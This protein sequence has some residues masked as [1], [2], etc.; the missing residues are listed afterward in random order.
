MF[1]NQINNDTAAAAHP[2]TALIARPS[3][4]PAVPKGSR[5]SSRHR[6]EPLRSSSAAAYAK[7]VRLFEAAG[8]IVP[9]D[10]AAI[11]DF[12][13]E[14]RD[15]I[16]PQTIYR[17]L[18]AVRNEHIRLGYA[19]PTDTPA[20]RP[21]LRQMQLGVAPSKPGTAPAPDTKRN[22]PRQARP[23]TRQLLAQVL[24]AMGTNA[25][26]RRDRCLLL[27]GFAAA[28]SRSALISLDAPDVRF[29]NDAMVVTIRTAATGDSERA[30]VVRI[31]FTGDELCAA[32]AT[33]AL[34]EHAQLD[35]EGG[36]L[37]RRHDRAGDPTQHRL[38]SAWVSVVVKN[39]L[40]DVGIDSGSYSAMS[41]R[42]GRLAEGGKGAV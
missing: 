23:I 4:S 26:D 7:D 25:L 10:A 31:P 5:R 20:L 33:R 8:G 32:T 1:S 27:L 36:P 12:I 37:F 24:A 16:A 9:C 30:R 15:K 2:H 13:G 18:M 17:R 34:I 28:L 35:V 22:E 41:L 11:H 19:S 21:V 39:R 14:M 29:N 3:T 42:R 38:D 40:K 6:T